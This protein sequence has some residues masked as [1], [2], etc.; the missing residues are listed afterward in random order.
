MFCS[1]CGLL[2]SVPAVTQLINFPTLTPPHLSR[3]MLFMT[4]P[5]PVSPGP[6]PVCV[7]QPRWTARKPL[8]RRVSLGVCFFTHSTFFFYLEHPALAFLHLT[9]P[10][11]LLRLSSGVT[12][13]RNTYLIWIFA[14][15][16]HSTPHAAPSQYYIYVFYFCFLFLLFYTVR[17]PEGW[18]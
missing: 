17:T 1:K 13:V 5:L 16:Y 2:V 9:K 3:Q 7:L 14:C 6:F 18:K 10:L 11:L 15:S 4:R 8:H 12:T